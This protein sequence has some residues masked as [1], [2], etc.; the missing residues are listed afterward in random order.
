[1]DKSIE[2]LFGY[3]YNLAIKQELW[4]SYMVI[5]NVQDPIT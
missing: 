2:I 3:S 5:S 1:M 4:K